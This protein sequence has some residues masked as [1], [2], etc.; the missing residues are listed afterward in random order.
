MSLKLF[1]I[2]CLSNSVP[3][4]SPVLENGSYDKKATTA[5]KT[6]ERLSL[7]IWQVPINCDIVMQNNSENREKGIAHVD[8]IPEDRGEGVE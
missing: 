7:T 4:A 2:S 1:E 5:K 8:F 3:S 6:G